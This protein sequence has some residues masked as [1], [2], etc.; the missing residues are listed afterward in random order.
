LR[1]I[2]VSSQQPERIIL[3]DNAS[4]DRSIDVAEAVDLP[5]LTIIRNPDNIGA[6]RARF[7]G[8][9]RVTTPYITFLDSD[10]LLGP[11]ALA[12]AL[13]RINKLGLN[14]SLFK[15]LRVSQNG[16]RI[17]SFIDVPPGVITGLRAFQ[18]TLGPWNIHAY[19][20][21]ETELYRE[22]MADFQCHGF[23]DDE[24]LARHL[25]L[26]ARRVAGSSGVYYYRDVEKPYTFQKVMGQTRTNLRVLRLAWERRTELDGDAPLR[27]MRNVVTRNLGG[28]LARIMRDGGDRDNLRDLYCEYA[29]IRVPWRARDAKYLAI[30]CACAIALRNR[31]GRPF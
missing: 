10:D 15:C 26:G 18:L 2:A 13:K 21:Y 4:T 6:T 14:V 22:A 17:S 11:E 24:V 28:L 5:N 25:F 16:D 12:E 30:H 20:V 8:S 31:A 7:I 1:S 29:A 19:G 9:E 3:V 23:S 27:R